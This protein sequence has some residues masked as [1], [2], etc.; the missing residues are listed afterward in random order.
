M[1]LQDLFID[2]QNRQSLQESHDQGDSSLCV[3]LSQKSSSNDQKLPPTRSWVRQTRRSP[4]SR[5]FIYNMAV[6]CL[7]NIQSIRRLGS[8]F[9]CS[10]WTRFKDNAHCR[11]K[12]IVQLFSCHS[13]HSF[14][15]T[16]GPVTSAAIHINKTTI[17]T[18][19]QS[20]FRA[21]AIILVSIL[22]NQPLN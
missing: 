7:E 15:S 21:L 6:V 5:L 2:T 3:P 12:N 19:Q 18:A 4:W 16:N 14:L 8:W 10:R 13:K 1:Y 17:T 11:Y 20:K 22:A 9:W